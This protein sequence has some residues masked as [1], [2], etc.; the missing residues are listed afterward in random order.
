MS[1]LGRKD[2]GHFHQLVRTRVGQRPRN[3]HIHGAE[4]RRRGADA[5][6]QR[7]HCDGRECWAT[8]ET[9]RG[10]P[11]VLHHALEEFDD[12]HA[13]LP[14]I[15][16]YM[17]LIAN[18]IQRRAQATNRLGTRIGRGHPARDQMLDAAG[19][20]RRELV[21]GVAFHRASRPNPKAKHSAHAR[22]NVEA[23]AAHPRDFEV[24]AERIE[25]IASR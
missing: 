12:A 19:D 24:L 13:T 7:E 6:A 17:E 4:D 2:Q 14:L 9:A 18:L 25:T 1:T 5:Y 16:V 22:A 8:R 11:D 15:G 20:E 10:I 23:H 21:V 3:E